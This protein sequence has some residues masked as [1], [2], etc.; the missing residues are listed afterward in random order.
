MINPPHWRPHVIPE[1]RKLLEHFDLIPDD[2]P[3]AQPL[4][5]LENPDPVDAIMAMGNSEP[6]VIWSKVLLPKYDQLNSKVQWR[7]EA[8][9]RGAQ[10]ERIN[11]YLLVVEEA[12]DDSLEPLGGWS[13]QRTTT[14]D[15]EIESHKAVREFLE[16]LKRGDR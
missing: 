1:K 4:R 5:C 9:M 2:S 3:D 8:S 13:S 15:P 7:L 6:M 10:R 11:Y 12:R 14:L 16:S